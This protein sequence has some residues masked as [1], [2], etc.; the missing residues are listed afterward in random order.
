[1]DYVDSILIR[2]ADSTTRDG[3]F[4]S[5]ALA[6]IASTAYDTG[7][8]T[9]EAPYSAI[10]DEVLPGYASPRRGS[11]EG[12]WGPLGGVERVLA[13]LQVA[14]ISG[15]PTVAVEAL[16]RGA[17]IAHT[18]QANSHI[19]KVATTWPPSGN[20]V[21][22]EVTVGVTYAPPSTPPSGTTSL[23]LV[24]AIFIRDAGFSLA[25]LLI[26]SR[27]AREQLAA[28][29]LEKN[30]PALPL[31]QSI[32]T[33][34]LVPGAVF[35]DNAWPGADT[36]QSAAVQRQQRLLAANRWLNP[37]GISVVTTN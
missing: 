2:L 22:H 23:P 32:V 14:D 19:D 13:Q 24:A 20:P 7:R 27:L 6:T 26:Q 11:I 29:G 4:S 8:L 5:N 12:M 30:N 3:L 18:T 25:Q 1:M 16:W 17:I 9:L 35:D 36:T 15:A 34:W 21:E 33:I 37:Q 10:F 31:R 28:L